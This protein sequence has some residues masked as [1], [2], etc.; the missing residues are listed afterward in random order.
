MELIDTHAHLYVEQ[1]K[2]DLAAMINRAKEDS[3]VK[4]ILPNI[5][6]DS[7]QSLIDLYLADKDFLCP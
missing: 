3:V 2:E 4:V 5:D 7:S 1:F 6:A